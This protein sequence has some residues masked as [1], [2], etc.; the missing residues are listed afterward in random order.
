MVHVMGIIL[1]FISHLYPCYHPWLEYRSGLYLFGFVGF[2]F[3][4]VCIGHKVQ[5]QHPLGILRYL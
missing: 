4:C 2:A 1:T 3:V 5:N